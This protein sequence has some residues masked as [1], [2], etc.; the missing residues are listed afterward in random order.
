MFLLN[1]WARG[2]WRATDHK[3]RKELI[4]RLK[5]TACTQ[6]KEIKEEEEEMG[7]RDPWRVQVVLENDWS[8][9]KDTG[10]QSGVCDSAGAWVQGS[11]SRS[12]RDTQGSSWHHAHSWHSPTEFSRISGKKSSPEREHHWTLLPCFWAAAANFRDSSCSCSQQPGF[13]GKRASRAKQKREERQ[14]RGNAWV[15]RMEFHCT[16]IRGLGVAGGALMW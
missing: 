15:P 7:K 11:L 10:L 16:E 3:G 14:A 1:P 5:A 8:H 6:L 4:P 9:Q 12:I 13:P 2:A